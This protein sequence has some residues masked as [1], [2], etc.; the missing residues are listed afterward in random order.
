MFNV[1]VKIFLT[2]LSYFFL[3]SGFQAFTFYHLGISLPF[4]LI[5]IEQIISNYQMFGQKNQLF[6]NDFI[7]NISKHQYFNR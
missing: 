4:C 5:K 6:F 2:Y 7:L 1:I 3:S